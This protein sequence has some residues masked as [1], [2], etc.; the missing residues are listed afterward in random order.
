[1]RDY[2]TLGSTPCNED[3][4]QVESGADYMPAMR[5]ECR[6]FVEGLRRYFAGRLIGS[7][8][9]GVKRESHDFGSYLEAAI[10]FDGDSDEE[11]NRA[12]SIENDTPS[13]WEELE[14]GTA[15]GYQGDEILPE[16]DDVEPVSILKPYIR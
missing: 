9:F 6:R 13:T 2:Y 12:C 14:T 4:V 15:P 10:Y 1:M 7:M 5:Q 16:T 11:T 3:C 8:T